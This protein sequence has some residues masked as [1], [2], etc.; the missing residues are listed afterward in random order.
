MFE[1]FI[2]PI[3]GSVTLGDARTTH[4]VSE[5]VTL[6]LSFVDDDLQ[7]HRRTVELVVFETDS[8]IIIGLPDIAR[9][10]GTLF[11]KMIQKAMD[12]P[13]SLRRSRARPSAQ[14]V[15]NHSY[16]SNQSLLM[17][18]NSE[19]ESDEELFSGIQLIIDRCSDSSDDDSG[20]ID[21]IAYEFYD[22]GS[23]NVTIPDPV[24]S[25]LWIEQWDIREEEEQL[26][27]GHSNDCSTSGENSDIEVVMYYDSGD[28]SIIS[29]SDSS[30]EDMPVV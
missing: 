8:H 20:P 15:I 16:W 11:I 18:S 2:R 4:S 13:T 12:S 19:S 24:D 17:L 25:D 27:H 5:V 28:E 1:P 21:D 10:F 22:H 3:Q 9:T 6:K 30:N 23:D 29:S 26:S 14:A 7:E